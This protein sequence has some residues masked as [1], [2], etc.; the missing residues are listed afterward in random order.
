MSSRPPTAWIK[1]LGA[2]A[3]LA[4]SGCRSA[5]S[6]RAPAAL[7]APEPA[8]APQ[9]QAAAPPAA[10]QL[11]PAAAPTQPLP[12]AAVLPHDKLS[13]PAARKKNEAIV[14]GSSSIKGRLGKVI[15]ADLERWGYDVT[16]RGVISVGL[17]RPDFKDL[18]KIVAGVPIDEETAAVFVYVGV[19]D[20]QSIW[21]RPEERARGESPWLPWHR[22]R[23][24]EVY[25]RRA[26]Q[27][28]Q[29]ICDRGAERA[30]VLLPIEVEKPRLERKLRRIRQ[31]QRRAAGQTTCA[32]AVSTTGERGEFT[33]NGKRLRTGDG[34][35]L[36]PLGARL[37]W[38]R[39]QR[40]AKLLPDSPVLYSSG[41][42]LAQEMWRLPPVRRH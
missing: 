4:C 9:R 2:L 42:R 30:F 14:V 8:A 41:E 38:N 34:F 17:A 36:S 37:V 35:H 6:E 7:L 22:P 19:N 29:S 15:A 26:Q 10:P 33:R 16:R 24:N 40:R 1:A 11:A 12:A 39:V 21:L 32:V 23:W 25:T 18:R 27:L 3:L 20:G 31:L 28:F 13:A 5:S